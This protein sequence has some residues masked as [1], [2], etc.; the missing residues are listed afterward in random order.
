VDLLHTNNVGA[1]PAP[2]AARR[3]GVPRLL[4][5]LHV[6][7]SYDLVGAERAR[8][9]L[10]LQQRSMAALDRAIA[11][12]ADTALAWRTHLG[13]R[14][15]DRPPMVVIPNGI[16]LDR[17]TRRRPIAE[18]KRAL[19][20]EP[21]DLVIGSLGR[22][23]YAKG[24][25]DL[26]EALPTILA[27]VPRARFVHAGRGPLAEALALEASRLGI[28]Q[29]VLWLG[30]RS[31]VRDLLEATDV[32]VQPSWCETQG[33]GVL[34]AGALGIAAV[35]TTAGGLPETVGDSSGWTVPPRAPEALAATIIAVLG[36]Q[37]D[38]ER[39][40]LR[41][42]ARVRAKFSH[43]RMVADTMLQYDALLT[44]DPR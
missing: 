23:D 3:A 32:Y 24:Y 27:N 20:L 44:Q 31:D 9:F 1:E 43:D 26:I 37:A 21:E 19:G 28:E 30:F 40:G 33:L 39:M 2:I 38:R 16:R 42:Q 35:T 12:S 41:F 34:E 8:R 11:V 22:L 13:L 15:T 10:R 17:L 18:A 14:D 4:G 7:P 25:A 29:R 5:T 36:N 6:D